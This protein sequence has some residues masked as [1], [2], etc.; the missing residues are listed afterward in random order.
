MIRLSGVEV[1][2]AK[3]KLLSIEDVSIGSGLTAIVGP[4]GA[5]KTTLL[6][7]IIG[8][9]ASVGAIELN[10][11]QATQFP[12]LERAR[13][14]A[15]LPQTPTMYWPLT[16]RAIVSLGRYPHG[17]ADAASGKAIVDRV[18]HE[19][20]LEAFAERT[21]ATLSGGERARVALARALAV[22]APALLADEPAAALDPRFQL[23]I[24]RRLAAIASNSKTVLV[25]THDLNAA[26]TYADRVLMISNGTLVADGPP[27]DVLNKSMISAIFGVVPDFAANAQSRHI[28]G[29]NPAPGD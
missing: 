13:L 22:D 7:A 17:D 24:Y 10:G 25:V 8:S 9:V 26:L 21:V 4:N 6:R 19:T 5:G 28:V 11:R 3:K 18:L 16:V 12:P 2:A 23:E 1:F 14:V 20:G 15:Y 27:G 29:Y